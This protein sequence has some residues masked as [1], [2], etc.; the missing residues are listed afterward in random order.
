MNDRRL[1][2]LLV[3]HD[4][5]DK[6]GGGETVYRKIIE[7]NPEIDFYYFRDKEREDAHR[8]AHAR[9]ILYCYK[10]HLEVLAPPPF[11]AYR[12]GA[13]EEADRIAGSVAGMA[14]DI[15][16]VPDY[17][18][19]GSLLRD[20]FDH[21]R[22]AVGRIVLAM[23]GNISHSIALQWGSAG[24]R[25]L[26]QRTLERDQFAAVDGVYG[27]SPRYIAEWQREVS[28]PVEY[29]DP[30]SL[31]LVGE[32]LEQQA[33]RWREQAGPPDLMCIGR[34][35]RLKGND[36]FI[37][38]A[39]ALS[40][41]LYDRAL[42]IGNEVMTV[43]GVSSRYVLENISAAR[44]VPF[45]FPGPMAPWDLRE[46]FARRA[47][48]VLP[49]RRDTLNLVALEALFSGCPV[50]VSIEAGVV[51]YLDRYLPE[52]PYVR[53]DFSDFYK[54]VR[55]IEA[56]LA[57]YD[58]YRERLET[59]VRNVLPRIRSARLD[60]AG[61]Y[62]R[63]LEAAPREASRARVAVAYRKLAVPLSARAKAL[64][65]KAGVVALV[66]TA[67]QQARRLLETV[68]RWSERSS[69]I[70]DTRTLQVLLDARH[71]AHRLWLVSCSPEYNLKRLREKLEEIYGY[72]GIPLYRCNFWRD[73][74]RIERTLGHELIAV[75][76]ELRLL[77]LLG[78]DV[79]NLLPEVT[80]T[81]RRHGFAREAEAA[82]ALY[83]DPATAP[84]RT[85]A[86]LEAALERNRVLAP[87]KF[88][89]VDDRRAA[90]TPR[91]SVI[92]SLYDAADKLRFFLSSLMRQSLLVADA[93]A[94]E[95][96]LIDSGSPGA[97]RDV[98][99][100]FHAETGLSAVYA[101]TAARETIQAAWNRGL[102]LARGDYIVCLGVDET[103]MADALQVMADALDA[104]AD[105]DWVVGDGIVTDV[106][107][108]GVYKNDCM[109][110]ERDGMTKEHVYLDTCYLTYVGGMYRRSVHSRH[111]YYDESFRGAGDTEFKN[112]VLPF[113]G[114]KAIPKVLGLFLNYP[115]ART[116]A[117]P[118]A[119]IE[120]LRAWYLHRSAG[121]VAYALRSR[122]TE[123][124]LALLVNALG[125]RKTYQRHTSTDLEYALTVARHLAGR[126]DA[127]VAIA[128]LIDGLEE[129]VGTLRALELIEQLPKPRA[130]VAAVLAAWRTFKAREREHQAVLGRP[131]NYTIFNDNRHEQ[132]AWLWRS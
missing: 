55:D 80:A 124:G 120:D 98:F 39:R 110:Y 129:M 9:A 21:H 7:A 131:L 27:I 43:D 4:L 89:H 128:A 99:E 122:P 51:D 50:A 54:A 68:R 14:F 28:R 38:I 63:V 23:H 123:V 84:A 3:T 88:A 94:V 121:G 13:L 82:E 31:V 77:R 107:A 11:A 58:G 49:V 125:Y 32:G 87:A 52:L 79:F 105:V 126:A 127:G 71:V 25:V 62:R 35:E 70:N 30:A 5:Y 75:A 92:V 46:A 60:I 85:E 108:Q 64:A 59:A 29:I 61:V 8:P 76:Y 119:E 90:A 22:V 81:L 78:R 115:E 66:N 114:V 24:D 95:V 10:R 57:D 111:G 109:R 42:H 118:M 44:G 106:D 17:F 100:A 74:A 97:E 16:D 67:R 41:G 96:I 40:P 56:V 72:V 73:I 48:V 116:T 18:T 26:E 113:I 91:I 6:V 104:A 101:R 65:R 2:V 19:F 33:R 20:A 15:V 86:L 117:S 112:R 45:H 12:R 69:R 37:E 1:R 93:N 53:I 47:M 102:S 103:L 132:H 36:L 130:C 34:T 83:G